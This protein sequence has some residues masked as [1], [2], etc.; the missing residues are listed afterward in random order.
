MKFSLSALHIK[1]A[2]IALVVIVVAIC[3]SLYEP[4]LNPESVPSFTQSSL[5][6]QKSGK[7]KQL[8]PYAVEVATTPEQHAYGVMYRQTLPA[9]TGMIFIYEPDQKVSMWMK[10]TYIPL[11][12]LFVRHDG[13]IVKITTNT[14]PHDLTPLASDEPIR[15]V[16]EVNAGDVEKHGFKTGDKVLFSAFSG[17]S[18]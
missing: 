9:D 13:V 8:I 11:D 17:T 18:K 2:L 10:N 7:G 14:T 5:A 6:I 3:L 1:T 4:P 12:L 16:I 15:A